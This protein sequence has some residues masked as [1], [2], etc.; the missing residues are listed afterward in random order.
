MAMVPAYTAPSSVTRSLTVLTTAMNQVVSTVGSPVR[1]PG[2]V[3]LSA[4]SRLCPSGICF[5]HCLHFAHKAITLFFN[6]LNPVGHIFNVLD[7]KMFHFNVKLYAYI[8]TRS[9]K[10]LID[11]FMT[12]DKKG[13]AAVQFSPLGPSD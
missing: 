6:L 8:L 10:H 3:L 11:K 12:L 4:F 2:S 13:Q 1:L 9:A 7:L 5:R